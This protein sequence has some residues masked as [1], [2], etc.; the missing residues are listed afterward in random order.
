VPVKFLLPLFN[1]FGRNGI[2]EAE[3]DELKDIP[4][5]KVRQVA[6][7]VPAFGCIYGGRDVRVQ[8]GRDVRVQS[9]RDVRAPRYFQFLPLLPLL[10]TAVGDL[11]AK[12]FGDVAHSDAIE[13]LGDKLP[14]L[15]EHRLEVFN[16]RQELN[17]AQA[18]ALDQPQQLEPALAHAIACRFQ[19]LQV[20][21]FR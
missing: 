16:W 6:A 20:E 15:P 17:D 2:M 18:H 1:H 8:S 21:F 10:R 4:R 12:R 5:V 14:L 7:G 19:L 9:G 3:G 13:G 11:P